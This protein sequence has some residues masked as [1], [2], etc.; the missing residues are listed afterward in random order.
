MAPSASTSVRQRS[1]QSLL[2][3][4]KHQCSQVLSH[5]TEMQKLQHLEGIC[6][7]ILLL[8]TW[9]SPN[10]TCYHLQTAFAIHYLINCYFQTCVHLT[11]YIESLNRESFLL[12]QQQKTLCLL[13]CGLAKRSPKH[14]SLK[15]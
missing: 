14:N 8:H 10:T 12:R 9:S 4:T 7:K 1:T 11:K 6:P 15:F 5:M 2:D 13:Q 3:E